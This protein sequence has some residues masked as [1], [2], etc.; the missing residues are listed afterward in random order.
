MPTTR[1]KN[2]QVGA[3]GRWP[4]FPRPQYVCWMLRQRFGPIPGLS[5]SLNA[6]IEGGHQF[7][8]VAVLC[9]QRRSVI[10]GLPGVRCLLFWACFLFGVVDYVRHGTPPS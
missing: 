9:R 6:R 7:S 8:V 2:A 10:V 3:A 5:E 4:L 1:L